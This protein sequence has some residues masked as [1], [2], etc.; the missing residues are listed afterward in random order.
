MA[1][2]HAAPQAIERLQAFC[3]ARDC[4][5]LSELDL[6]FRGPGSLFGEEQSGFAELTRFRPD[7]VRLIEEAKAAVTRLM[8][9]DPDL[10]GHDSLKR[11]VSAE[12]ETVHLE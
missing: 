3:R 1:A 6:R 7:D 10:I 5:E 11:K 12:A 2:T 8:T 9:D 4:F